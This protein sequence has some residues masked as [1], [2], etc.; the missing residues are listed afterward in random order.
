MEI[1]YEDFDKTYIKK[2]D[3]NNWLAKHFKSEHITI[4]D[5]L[6]TI[7]DLDYDVEHL[8]DEIRILESDN[9]DCDEDAYMERI[10]LGI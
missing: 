7:E 1:N 6:A 5:L 10:R 8:Q 9:T 2:E 3:L 4:N